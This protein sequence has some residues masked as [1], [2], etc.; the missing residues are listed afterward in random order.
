MKK[1]NASEEYEE[2]ILNRAFYFTA[3]RGRQVINRI[4]VVFD[5]LDEAIAYAK[6]HGDNRTMIYAVD[7]NGRDAHICNA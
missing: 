5:S 4:R 3:V 6:E 1:R 7:E 2:T